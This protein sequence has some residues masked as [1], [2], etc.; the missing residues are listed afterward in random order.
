MPKDL[1]EMDMNELEGVLINRRKGIAKESYMIGMLSRTAFAQDVPDSPEKAFPGMYPK[2]KSYKMP[3]FLKEKY[4]RE[5]GG[6][7]DER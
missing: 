6:G 2:P 7:I 1:Y 3:D 4:Y 5:N